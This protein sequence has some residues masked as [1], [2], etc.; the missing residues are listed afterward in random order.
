MYRPQDTCK[1]KSINRILNGKNQRAKDTFY[2]ISHSS[3]HFTDIKTKG[4]MGI[5]MHSSKVRS[6]LSKLPHTFDN[7]CVESCVESCRIFN[8]YQFFR[9]KDNTDP[10]VWCSSEG[11]DTHYPKCCPGYSCT[12]TFS[13]RHG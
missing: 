7:H 10:N 4:K 3:L 13:H 11:K 6:I 9:C 12:N 5:K 1:I 8:I 2:K